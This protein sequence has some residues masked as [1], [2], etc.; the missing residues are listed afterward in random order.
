MKETKMYCDLCKKDIDSFHSYSLD[1]M[2]AA[3]KGIYYSMGTASY[4]KLR[5]EWDLCDECANRIYKLICELK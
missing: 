4:P 1:L 2:F 3:D 5:I